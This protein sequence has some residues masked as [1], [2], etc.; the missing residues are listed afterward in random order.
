MR[1]FS[2]APW[3]LKRIASIHMIERSQHFEVL[4]TVAFKAAVGGKRITIIVDREAVEDCLRRTSTTHEDRVS[5]MLQNRQRLIAS[6]ERYI[7]HVEDGEGI[8]L[9]ASHIRQRAD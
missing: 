9:P 5:F 6:A 7:E 2:K 4:D 8:M 1:R 3:R